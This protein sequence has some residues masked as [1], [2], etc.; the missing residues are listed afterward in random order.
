MSNHCEELMSMEELESLMDEQETSN[1]MATTTTTTAITTTTTAATAATA[2]TTTTTSATTKTVSLLKTIQEKKPNQQPPPIPIPT[3]MSDISQTAGIPAKSPEPIPTQI[4]SR[5]SVFITEGREDHQNYAM[6]REPGWGIHANNPFNTCY[7]DGTSIDSLVVPLSFDEPG[8]ISSHTASMANTLNST[9]AKP[10]TP[11][12]SPQHQSATGNTF[13][14]TTPSRNTLA[15][16][17]QSRQSSPVKPSPVAAH[18][19][20]GL[21]EVVIISFPTTQAQNSGFQ[22]LEKER[23]VRDDAMAISIKI[24]ENENEK[25]VEVSGPAG[26][27]IRG[28]A[29][30][31]CHGMK[32]HAAMR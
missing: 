32:V 30:L 28:F 2:D 6:E 3:S 19:G 17:S 9:L 22:R 27:N 20:G 26:S 24:L 11:E 21:L 12:F 1:A 18:T 4:L 7:F 25:Q 16:S 14:P 8:P 5:I 31:I 15:S 13:V 29:M 23:E 10:A